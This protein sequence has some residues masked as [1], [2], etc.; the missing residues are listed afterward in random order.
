MTP[1]LGSALAIGQGT[2]ALIRV[3]N[4]FI[5][6]FR[7]LPEVPGGDDLTADVAPSCLISRSGVEL[8]VGG[9][10]DRSN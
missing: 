5:A 8:D 4:P 7:Y 3:V 6:Q 9:H 1:A 10:K 2:L